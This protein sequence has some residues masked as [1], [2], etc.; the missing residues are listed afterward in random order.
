MSKAGFLSKAYAAARQ[1]GL[2]PTQ[3]TL[4]A[5]QA[6][7]ETGYGVHAPKNNMFGIKAGK[8][9]KGGVQNLKTKE[10]VGGKLVSTRANFRTYPSMAAA[11][12]DWA[13]LVERNWPAAMAASTFEEALSALKTGL[14]GGYATA[15]NY[16]IGANAAKALMDKNNIQRAYERPDNFAAAG[17]L[18]SFNVDAG[19]A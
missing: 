17:P 8:S 2:N 6:A 5:A 16:A 14:P 12:K 13:R 3:A 1:A 15:T 19:V 9:W 4:A 7:H 18:G 11:F 10:E